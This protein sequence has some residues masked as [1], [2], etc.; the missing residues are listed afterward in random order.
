MCSGQRVEML[1]PFLPAL[2]V[3][4]MLKSRVPELPVPMLSSVAPLN[5]TP[6][7]LPKHGLVAQLYWHG[8]FGA[9]LLS[10]SPTTAELFVGMDRVLFYRT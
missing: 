3:V 1:Q 9:E 2:E 10:L 4:R 6:S 7:V 8:R 5:N